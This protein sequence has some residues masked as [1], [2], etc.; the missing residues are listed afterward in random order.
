[1]AP[2]FLELL[3]SWYPELKDLN[4][5]DMAVI[6]GAVIW[7]VLPLPEGKSWPKPDWLSPEAADE[8][9]LDE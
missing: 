8:V 3:R 7:G 6:A 5:E 4:D 1:M 2:S 9:E